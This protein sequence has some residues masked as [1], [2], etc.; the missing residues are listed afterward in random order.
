MPFQS[1]SHRGG[2]A[3]LISMVSIRKA[4]LFQSPSHRGG[5]APLMSIYLATEQE[6][7]NPLL[8]GAGALPSCWRG[9]R[10]KYR[11]NPLLIGAG[12]LPLPKT[13]PLPTT[14]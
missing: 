12:A 13:S 14:I 4:R 3:P 5:S 10:P 7:F 2:S 1:P 11:F 9:F 8:I 6:S